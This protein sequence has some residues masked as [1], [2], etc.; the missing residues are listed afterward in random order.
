MMIS[1]QAAG[2]SRPGVA[3]R[4]SSAAGA[5]AIPLQAP[6][7]LA[8]LP[9]GG[10]LAMGHFSRASRARSAGVKMMAASGAEAP[11][12]AERCDCEGEAGTASVN[13]VDVSA[14]LIRGLALTDAEGNTKMVSDVIG[15]DGKAVV[16]FLR[17]LG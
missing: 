17:H 5:R 13:G 3:S 4:R 6:A 9:Q 11:V 1:L 8:S 7:P 12:A 16:V 14:D 10:A 2:L 15:T